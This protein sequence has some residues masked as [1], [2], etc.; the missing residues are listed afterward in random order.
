MGKGKYSATIFLPARFNKNSLKAHC[1]DGTLFKI[2]AW[3]Q[4]C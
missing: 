2:I 1:K 3:S 4:A